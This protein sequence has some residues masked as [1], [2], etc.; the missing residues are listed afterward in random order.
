[1][2]FLTWAAWQIF[3]YSVLIWILFVAIAFCA[4]RFLGWR[5][6]AAS[7]VASAV[8]FYAIDLRQ[9][10]TWDIRPGFDWVAF[11]G[12]I[13]RVV[14]LSVVLLPISALGTWLRQ[15]SLPVTT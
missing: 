15:R 14:V 13:S 7:L 6:I 11:A 8:I 10:A 3:Q 4:T 2:H 1:M 5:G 9:L 12:I